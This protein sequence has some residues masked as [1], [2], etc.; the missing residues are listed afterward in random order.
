MTALLMMCTAFLAVHL[1]AA[2]QGLVVGWIPRWGRLGR[3]RQLQVAMTFSSSPK[4]TD[5]PRQVHFLLGTEPVFMV[6]G[7]WTCLN[8]GMEA[9]LSLSAIQTKACPQIHFDFIQMKKI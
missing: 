2:D 1:L 5:T 3:R 4:T 6:S 9:T 8:L 7:P